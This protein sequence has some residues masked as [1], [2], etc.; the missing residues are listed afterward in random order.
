M[1]YPGGGVN[2]DARVERLIRERTVVRYARTTDASGS[3]APQADR[4][5]FAPTV[6]HLDTDAMFA[7]GETFLASESEAPLASFLACASVAALAS[8]AALGPPAAPPASRRAP[9]VPF[10]SRPL[11]AIIR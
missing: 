4:F 8:A 5:A 10:P 3:F 9:A 7:L 2:H 1:A 6:Y 11:C